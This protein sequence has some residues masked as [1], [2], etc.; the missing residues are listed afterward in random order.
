MLGRA[1][2]CTRRSR[3]N[4]NSQS[5]SQS[6]SNSGLPA[7]WRGGADCGGRRKYLHVA[8]AAAS[9]PRTP[10]QPDP[11]RLRQLAAICRKHS[12]GQIRFP[13]ENGSD[14]EFHSI[15]DRCADQRSAPTNSHRP[16]VRG[17]AGGGGGGGGGGRGGAA[18]PPRAGGG[19]GGAPPPPPAPPSLSK[20]AVAVAVAPALSRCRAQPCRNTPNHDCSHLSPRPALAKVE[21]L[22]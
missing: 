19:G 5:N 1:A 4:G 3:S 9:M 10:P 20:S 13:Q 14:P 2:T 17:G 18:P 8:L 11:P 7:G 21:E 12:W 22:T 16:A 6:N 15:S